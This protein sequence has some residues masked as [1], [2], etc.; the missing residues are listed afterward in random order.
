MLSV[1]AAAAQVLGKILQGQGSLSSLLPAIQAK[2]N[3]KD[4]PLLQELCFGT[5]RFHPQLSAYIECLVDKP[6]RAKDSDIQALLLLGLYQLLHTRIP[7][8]AALSE[9]VEAARALKK[10]WATTLING[11][12]RKFQ[13]DKSKLDKLLAQNFAFQN[14]H[15]AWIEGVLRKYWPEQI[16]DIIAANNI[17]PPFTLRL[18]THKVSREE[19]LRQLDAQSINAKATQFSPYGI[20]LEQ[21]CDPR[22]LPL[23]AEGGISVQDEAAQLSAD[24]LELSPN[25]RILD[26]CSAP[27]GKTGHMLEREPS[28]EVLALDADERRLARVRE[29]LLRLNVQAAVCSGDATQPESWWDG[30]LFDRILLD[31]PCS[32]TGII[33]RH[34][35]IKILRTPEELDRL[36]KLQLQ[37]LNKLW[38]LLKPGGILLYATCS[39][40]PKENTHIV[41]SFVNRHPDAICDEL[42]PDWGLAQAYGR[43]LLPQSTAHDG[44][45]YARLRKHSP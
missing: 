43:Q 30:Q 16:E 33:R 18:N 14:N 25:L 36:A 44:F 19:Y 35:D 20:T 1:R 38:P 42:T 2:V 8:H 13:R 12:L 21:A 41:E 4:R 45:Y 34:P 26:A 15:P 32:A 31:A 39:I 22:E 9:T 24:L 5:C 37:L 10:S 23:F 7:D 28:L 6:L 3:E 27:G 17:H 29:N 40:M 11:V